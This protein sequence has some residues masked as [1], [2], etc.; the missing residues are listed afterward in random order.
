MRRFLLHLAFAISLS[1]A[2]CS[3][4]DPPPTTSDVLSQSLHLLD[5][6]DVDPKNTIPDAVLNGAKCLV[7]LPADSPRGAITCRGRDQKWA[8]PALVEPVIQHTA[9]LLMVM[10][11]GAQQGITTGKQRVWGSAP[12]PLTRDT[13]LATDAQL[14]ADLLAYRWDGGILSGAEMGDIGLKTVAADAAPTL[15]RSFLA[16]VNSFANTIL[17]SG[18]II[19]HSGV[20]PSETVDE[21]AVDLFHRE[22]GFDVTC[23]GREYHVAYHY[24]ILAD[25]TVQ[26]GRP[27][28]CEGAHA[29][30]YNSY[31][32]IALVGDFSKEDNPRGQR[33]LTTPT[34]KQ[35]DALIR[36]C[37]ELRDHYRI[38][39]QR[40]LRHSDIS[41]PH[42]PGDR[43]PFREL[44]RAL[45]RP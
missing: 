40:V 41:T 8:A 35:M 17:P 20:V 19:H 39:L 2:G 1:L 26:P 38:P 4:S 24:L 42:C 25:G 28:R 6:I 45:E 3:H 5:A 11:P 9:R 33:G 22:R 44:M 32:G 13:P 31:L 36:L 7:I 23:F 10:S 18:I 16:S 21:R 14:K 43:F 34:R 37:R 15:T 29:R 30:G 27:E 12:G